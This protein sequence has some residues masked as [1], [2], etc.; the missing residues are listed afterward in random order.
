MRFT[1][2]GMPATATS[3]K[4][5]PF[6]EGVPL[7]YRMSL[8]SGQFSWVKQGL[9][10]QAMEDKWF[11]YYEDP[12]LF[13]HRSWTGE[14]VYRLTLN[15]VQGGAE[16]AKRSGPSIWR[17]PPRPPKAQSTKCACLI[18]YCLTSYSA[19]QSLSR[20]QTIIRTQ[21]PESFSTSSLELAIRNLQG[22][23]NLH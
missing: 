7:P 1:I 12:H 3:W 4:R 11:I 22:I 8:D 2:D 6:T 15:S 10:P 21:C 19:S 17:M 16:I 9:I 18:S 5:E 23:H 14:P 13:L 20:C